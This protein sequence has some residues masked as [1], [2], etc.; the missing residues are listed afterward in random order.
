MATALGNLE[1][2]GNNM[3]DIFL[4]SKE[5]FHNHAPSFNFEL[6]EEEL[7][8]K[9]I[10]VGF[11]TQVNNPKSTVVGQPEYLYMV[12]SDYRTMS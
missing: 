10:A 6:G 4:T 9:A 11:V 12:N 5:L 7:V 2:S 3:S 1:S 8:A